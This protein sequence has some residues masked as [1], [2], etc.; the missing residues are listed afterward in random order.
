[1]EQPVLTRE[2]RYSGWP[3]AYCL[4]CGLPDPA[5][6]GIAHG[7]IDVMCKNC[8]K[9]WPQDDSCISGDTIEWFRPHDL[10]WDGCGQH[11]DGI[12]RVENQEVI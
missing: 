9:S 4:D 7:C 6:E 8:G 2:H 12:C 1:M 5:E 11:G 3:G 10:V